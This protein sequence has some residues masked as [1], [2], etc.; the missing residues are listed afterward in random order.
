MKQLIFVVVTIGASL[1]AGQSQVKKSTI[2]GI[3][4]FA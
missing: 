3:T 2:E 1:A 4:N